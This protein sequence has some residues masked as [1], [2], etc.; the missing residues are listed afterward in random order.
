VC[1]RPRSHR[2]LRF[3]PFVRLLW[4]VV[5]FWAASNVTKCNKRHEGYTRFMC[6][7]SFWKFVHISTF[8]AFR[9]R[10]RITNTKANT[11]VHG[12]QS[13]SSWLISISINC[14]HT[15]N[16]SV[17][18][19]WHRYSCRLPL[20]VSPPQQLLL[21]GGGGSGV[22]VEHQELGTEAWNTLVRSLFQWKT[23][24]VTTLRTSENP[25]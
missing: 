9:A 11:R 6:G 16:F 18:A 8:D 23:E 2:C 3:G 5:L 25:S 15:L 17:S 22:G 14:L 7:C 13:I 12:A 4:P 21:F 19:S 1:G 20:F 24:V 10:I